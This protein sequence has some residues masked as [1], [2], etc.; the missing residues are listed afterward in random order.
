MTTRS[1]HTPGPWFA[2]AVR[3]GRIIGG[4]DAAL[5]DRIQI[6]SHNATVAS[7]YRSEDARLIAVAPKL[8]AL[9][10]AHLYWWGI[11][12]S[13]VQEAQVVVMR[14]MRAAIAE[15]EGGSQ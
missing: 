3:L 4:A 12:E 15:A 13:H 8:L 6:N 11:Q 5:A 9:V 1:K 10:K 7:V 2:N 14:E